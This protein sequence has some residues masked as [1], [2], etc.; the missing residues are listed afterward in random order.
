MDQEKQ[1]FINC[2]RIAIVGVS[3]SETKFGNATYK[4]LKSRGLQVVPVHCEMEEFDGD[5]CYRTIQEITPPVEGVFINVTPSKVIT[6]LQDAVQAGVKYIWLQQG[7]ESKEAFQYSKEHGLSIAS[8]GCI[9]M[10]SEP[11]KSF[12]SIHRWVWKVVGKY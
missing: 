1:N 11:V 7:S 3:R 9:L 8:N 5:H 6:V 10:Y 2:K 12:H 4:E